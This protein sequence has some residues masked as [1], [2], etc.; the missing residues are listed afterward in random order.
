MYR[1]E[2]SIDVPL[3]AIAD[4]A[5]VA[6][7]SILYHFKSRLG[8]LAEVAR[9]VYVELIEDIE[10]IED[11]R[12]ADPQR[13][14]AALL[15]A[16]ASPAGFV[17]YAIGDELT[18]AGELADAD[19]YPHLQRVLAAQGVAVSADITAAALTFFGRRLAFGLER[20]EG[21][22]PFVEGLASHGLF[23]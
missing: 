21:I 18:S 10:D 9:T 3:E 2:R 5:G 22:D 7:G 20:P 12:G 17:L 11:G 15:G 8:L 6:K 23:G 1:S 19:P 13:W 14:S 4:T 16:L